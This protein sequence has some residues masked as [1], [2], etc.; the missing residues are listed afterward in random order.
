MYMYITLEQRQ[1]IR[2]GQ[3]VILNINLKSICIFHA[4]FPNKW[5]LTNFT[6]SDALTLSKSLNHS[7]VMLYISFVELHSSMLYT[8]FQ[9]HGPSGSGEDEFKGFCYLRPLHP[10][11]SC[12]V[13]HFH[14]HSFPLPKYDPHKIWI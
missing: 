8:K 2:T 11:W 9:N 12:D 10:S 5:H 14:K 3:N 13:D 4:N 1:T 7:T 6:H